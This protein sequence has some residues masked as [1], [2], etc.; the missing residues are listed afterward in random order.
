M[1][2]REVLLKLN[3]YLE[4]ELDIFTNKQVEKHLD[5][6]PVCQNEFKTLA[7]TL[8][9]IKAVKAPPMPRDYSKIIPGA[10]NSP[11]RKC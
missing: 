2:C 7:R 11:E 5:N 8:R 9:I 10:S 6:C 3:P 4:K 1:N